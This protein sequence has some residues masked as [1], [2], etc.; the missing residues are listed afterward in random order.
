MADCRWPGCPNDG[1]P[2]CKHH[3]F[4][5]P[6]SKRGPENVE[7]ALAWVRQAYKMPRWQVWCEPLKPWPFKLKLIGEYDTKEAAQEAA[8]FEDSDDPAPDKHEFRR[9]AVVEVDVDPLKAA[10]SG[11][12][13]DREIKLVHVWRNGN[14]MNAMMEWPYDPTKP[15]LPTERHTTGVGEDAVSAVLAG[16][17]NL[18]FGGLECRLFIVEYMMAQ[19][20]KEVSR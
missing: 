10:L 12:L 15:K 17:A 8:Y 16:L 1:R 7:A 3:F 4:Y 5:L 18:G 2:F 14:R 13:A 20:T 6:P 11:W 19:L 9:I